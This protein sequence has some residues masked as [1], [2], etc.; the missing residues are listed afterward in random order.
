MDL[1]VS[2]CVASYHLRDD[3]DG[4]RDRISKLKKTMDMVSMTLEDMLNLEEDE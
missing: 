3:P 2:L 1:R 4:V